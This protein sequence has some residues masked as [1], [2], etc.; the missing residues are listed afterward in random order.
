[1]FE[2]GEAG[3]ILSRSPL[4]KWPP[5]SQKNAQVRA[6][7]QKLLWESYKLCAWTKRWV[8]P[9]GDGAVL[10]LQTWLFFTG[11]GE[12]A[13]GK[14]RN[15]RSDM[16]TRARE[17]RATEVRAREGRTREAVSVRFYVR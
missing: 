11:V 16:T 3:S 9:G 6:E 17:A 5:V 8:Q 10:V 1:M 4:S 12:A 15:F 2:A 14:A 7:V 13:D